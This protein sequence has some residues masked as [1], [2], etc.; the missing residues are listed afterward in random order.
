MTSC[1]GA[2]QVPGLT[3]ELQN[4]ARLHGLVLVV[5]SLRVPEGA[6]PGELDAVKGALLREIAATR[7]RVVRELP[8]LPQ[9]VLEASDGT[10]RALAASRHVLRVEESI[11]RAPAPR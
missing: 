3:P 11:P 7:H 4:K 6:T 8:G 5:V 10:L 2:S 9:I 1:A